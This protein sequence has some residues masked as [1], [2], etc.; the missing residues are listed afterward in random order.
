MNDEIEPEESFFFEPEPAAEPAAEPE[1]DW[2]VV[3]EEALD[4]L[5]EYLP[6]KPQWGNSPER[7]KGFLQDQFELVAKAE[8]MGDTAFLTNYARAVQLYA[9]SAQI[10]IARQS[11]KLFADRVVFIVR[12]AIRLVAKV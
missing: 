3:A 10:A 1:L 11:Q 9:E 4:L 2:G 6:A 7:L 12:L 5:K 8:A